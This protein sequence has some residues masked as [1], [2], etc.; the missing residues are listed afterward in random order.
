[1]KV[2]MLDSMKIRSLWF[3]ERNSS[4][5]VSSHF[6][7]LFSLSAQH[8]SWYL[9]WSAD[10]VWATEVA[11]VSIASTHIVQTAATIS[12]LATLAKEA[13]YWKAAIASHVLLTAVWVAMLQRNALNVLRVSDCR[14]VCAHNVIWT[15][16]VPNVIK[17]SALPAKMAILCLHRLMAHKCA[18]LATAISDIVKLALIKTLALLAHLD[19]LSW[20]K[21]NAFAILLQTGTGITTRRHACV[22]TTFYLPQRS[23]LLALRSFLGASRVITYPA[24]EA[25]THTLDS[26]T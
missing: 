10:L 15:E 20:M 9:R 5:L 11:L 1:M 23:A 3:T 21:T 7:W 25:P 8:T 4:S 19:L 17:I 2:Q 12:S 14:M 16:T 22:M 24:M 13:M 6:W 26:Q 18:C